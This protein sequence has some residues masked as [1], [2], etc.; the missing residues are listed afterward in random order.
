MSGLSGADPFPRLVSGVWTIPS[1]SGGTWPPDIPI[2]GSIYVGPPFPDW[3]IGISCYRCKKLLVFVSGPYLPYIRVAHLGGSYSGL[4]SPLDYCHE[5]ASFSPQGG[6]ET[7]EDW[8]REVAPFTSE[9]PCY[10]LADWCEEQG[11]SKDA[12]WLR[13]NRSGR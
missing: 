8:I 11:R 9:T 1:L 5:C 7:R 13:T 3:T 10:V 12:Q 2:C 4:Q 6:F